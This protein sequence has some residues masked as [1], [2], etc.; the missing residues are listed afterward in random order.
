[1]GPEAVFFI[2]VVALCFVIADDWWK[3]RLVKKAEAK[4]KMARKDLYV[5]STRW[6]MVAVLIVALGAY[7]CLLN[8]R[9]LANRD[10]GPLTPLMHW[11]FAKHR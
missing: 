11:L 7:A 8:R 6:G 9:E 10:F 4:G 5:N 1:M 2:A 3:R